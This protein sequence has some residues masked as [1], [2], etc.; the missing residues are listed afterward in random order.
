MTLRHAIGGRKRCA[1]REVALRA[2]KIVAPVQ[3][4]DADRLLQLTNA[5]IDR[6]PCDAQPLCLAI[7]LH[8][9]RKAAKTLAMDNVRQHSHR[10]DV[11]RFAAERAFRKRTRHVECLARAVASLHASSVQRTRL[12]EHARGLAVWR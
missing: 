11:S 2:N 6:H 8:F 9:G 1:T 10:R 3:P 4:F 5:V 7:G 12:T